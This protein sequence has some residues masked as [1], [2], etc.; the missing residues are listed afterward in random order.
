MD[1]VSLA[2]QIR[3]GFEATLHT[4]AAQEAHRLGALCEPLMA[5]V[6]L[7]Q[8]PTLVRG[9]LEST[10][11]N[12]M[13]AAVVRCYQRGP[14]EVWGFVVLEMLAPAIMDVAA[15]LYLGPASMTE[16]DLYQQ[17]A[18]EV[19]S[20]AARVRTH[21]PRWLKIRIVKHV[22]KRMSR[23]LTAEVGE[24]HD[25]QDVLDGVVVQP[26][27]DDPDW[28]LDTSALNR[29]KVRGERAAGIAEERG[30]RIH[31]LRYR[32]RLARQRA[33]EACEVDAA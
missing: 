25:G 14:R 17:L 22:K 30:M 10:E 3:T 15:K 29:M 12:E 21:R 1:T 31:Q 24:D 8:L 26:D 7:A 9:E 33:R 20:V 13:L 27:W 23:R 16:E 18:T 19:L 32:L 4:K 2:D 28:D 11:A 5:G 6:E